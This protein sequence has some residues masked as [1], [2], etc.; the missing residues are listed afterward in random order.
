M[1]ATGLIKYMNQTNGGKRGSLHWGRADIDGAPF[2]G[3]LPPMLP[4]E[5]LD[6][7]LVRIADPRNRVFDL[8]DPTDNAAY[9]EAVDKI[10]NKWGHLMYIKRVVTRNKKT[11]AIKVRV[12]MEWVEF[13]MEDGQ[14]MHSQRPYIGKPND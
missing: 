13:Y 10:V 11:D 4:E 12:Y 9:L 7:R 3:E 6:E 1:A 14:P 5:E 2:R 8:S